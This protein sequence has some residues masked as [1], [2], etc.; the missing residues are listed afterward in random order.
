M[1]YQ[2]IT[3]PIALILSGSVSSNLAFAYSLA[4]TVIGTDFYKFFE[5]QDIPDP[6]SGR[7]YVN[8]SKY[9]FFLAYSRRNYVDQET[10][11]KAGLTRASADSFILRA[12]NT[13]VL[14][15]LGPGRDSVRIKSVKTYTKHVVV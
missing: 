10:S 13:T 4:D 8:Q 14:K 15:T 3:I 9:L 6:L 2:L 12:D 1:K 11:K 7:V 5:W